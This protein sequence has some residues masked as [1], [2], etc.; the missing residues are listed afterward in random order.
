M[1]NINAQELVVSTA[2]LTKKYRSGT[3]A[4]DNVSISVQ[5]GQIY[6][7]LGQNGAGKTTLMRLLLGLSRPTAGTGVVLGASLGDS[8]ATVCVGSLIEYP[9]FYPSLTGERNL[10]LLASYC[11]VDNTA[12]AR[13]LDVVGLG[14]RARSRFGSY[15]LGMK[16]RIGIAAALLGDPELLILDEP[17]NGLDP[18]AIAQ[19][20]ELLVTLKEMGRTIVLSSHLLGEVQLVVDHVGILANGALLYEGSLN[21]L[22]KKTQGV[23]GRTVLVIRVTPI[24][25][26]LDV[27]SKESSVYDVRALEGGQIELSTTGAVG[28]IVRQ[29]VLAGVSVADVSEQVGT[30]EDVFLTMTS[31]GKVS[32]EAKE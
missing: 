31:G 27:L 12:V 30:L 24:E 8:V 19:T 6:G 13:V 25:T 18:Q 7:L 23:E 9:A 4:L 5:R 15:S 21:E 20:R 1:T 14:D 2:G 22:Q 28:E 29:L 10:R 17:T 3:V 26:A 32:A 11:G 16:Q